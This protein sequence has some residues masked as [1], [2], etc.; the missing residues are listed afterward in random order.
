MRPQPL[1][2]CLALVVL[3]PFWGARANPQSAT[4]V[5]PAA[6][7]ATPAAATP[8]PAPAPALP[9][10][11]PDKGKVLTYTCQGCHGIPGYKN[12]Y[13]SFRVPKIGGQ[14]SQYLTQALVEYRQ[15]KRKHPTMQAQAQSFSDQDIADIAA[16]LS[17]L[18]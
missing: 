7:P 12:A 3:L 16:F 15:G 1:A 14:S 4:P 8:A 13:P 2:A 10:G 17:T 9:T 6:T 11:S 18:K 5:S